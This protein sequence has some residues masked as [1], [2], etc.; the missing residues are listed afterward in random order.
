MYFVGP[1]G[2]PVVLWGILYSTCKLLP[3]MFNQIHKMDL[4]GT[5]VVV[6]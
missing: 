4:S 2:T 5:L 6:L 1:E 3:P